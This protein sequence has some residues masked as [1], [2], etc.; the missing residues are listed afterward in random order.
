MRAA[1]GN[2]MPPSEQEAAAA[3]FRVAFWNAG[4]MWPLHWSAR[5]DKQAQCSAL[6]KLQW[7]E[8]SLREIDAPDVV[9]LAEVGARSFADARPL[10]RVLK[11]HGFS[12]APLV[13]AEADSNGM[14]VAYRSTSAE[15][16]QCRRLEE[17]TV[18]FELKCLLDDSKHAFVA[19]HGLHAPL[20]RWRPQMGSEGWSV[21]EDTVS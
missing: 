3:K 12:M 16:I 6:S 13:L 1:H 18:G 9:I 21:G 15:L 19:I 17:R 20:K 10:G 2:G 14:V 7:L 5:E 4:G 11:K 8:S